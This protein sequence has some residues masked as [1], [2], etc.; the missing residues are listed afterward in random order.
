MPAFN[1]EISVSVNRGVSMM[2]FQKG[3]VRHV[4]SAIKWYVSSHWISVSAQIVM[5]FR[6]KMVEATCMRQFAS[7]FDSESVLCYILYGHN[8]WKCNCY[9]SQIEYELQMRDCV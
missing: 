7:K 4:L 5:K 6:G 3:T 9:V 2:S 1:V 8:L